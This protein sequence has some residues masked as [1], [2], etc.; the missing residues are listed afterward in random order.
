ME[1]GRELTGRWGEGSRG[2]A[3]QMLPLNQEHTQNSEGTGGRGEHCCVPKVMK[4]SCV[5]SD[6]KLIMALEARE[7]GTIS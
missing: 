7:N 4:G 3:R 1:G 2:Q 5:N 6:F